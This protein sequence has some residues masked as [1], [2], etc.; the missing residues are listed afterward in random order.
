M[1]KAAGSLVWVCVTTLAVAADNTVETRPEATAGDLSIEQLGNI[2]VPVVEGASKYKQKTTEA[3]SSVTIIVSDEIKKQGY[4]TLADLLRNVPGLYVSYDRLYSFLGIRGFNLG[5]YNNRVLLLINGHRINDSL[6]DGAFIGTE[7]ILDVDLID[8]VE[9]IRGPGSSLYG[10]N[11]F[12]A[13]INVITR[14]GRDM[15][16]NGAEVSG[17]AASHDSY[18]G[19]VSY[20]KRFNNGLELLLSGTI[21]ESLGHGTLYFPDFDQRIHPE[22]LRAR[23][24]GVAR[25]LDADRFKSAFGSLGFR[26]FS[27][28]GGYI[29]REKSNPTA[30]NASDFNDPRSR[31]TD[32]RGYAS[33]KYAH[34]FPGIVDVSA[35]LYYD[36]HESRTFYPFVAQGGMLIRDEQIGEWWGT[37]VQFIKR[38]WERLTLTLGG[39]YRDDFRQEERFRNAQ[40]GAIVGTPIETNRQNYGIYLEGDLAILTNLHV[41]AGFRYDQYGDYD[42]A[43]NPRAALIYNPFDES[44]FKFIYGTAFRAPNFFELRDRRFASS[45]KPE[46]ISTYELVYEQGIAKHLRSSVAGFYNQIDD[47]IRFEGGRYLNIEGADAK[48][49]ELSLDAAWASGIRG[50]ISYTFQH[51]EDRASGDR[52]TDS[53]EHL[54]ALSLTAPVLKDKIFAS[55]QLQYVSRRTT[56]FFDA[57]TQTQA[58]GPDVAGHAIVNLTLF[59]QNLAKGLDLSASVYN[60]LDKRYSDPATPFHQQASIE[61]DRRTFRVKLTYRF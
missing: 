55:V 10:A 38:M 31:T 39:E 20:G 23:D 16:G 7:F 18:K 1:I 42:P 19:R 22:V 11:A 17:E 12:F 58:V 60:V 4:R 26:D 14:K 34:S 51:T 37:E 15:A 50:R 3:P 43:F 27:V 5:D 2:E 8:R 25:N 56:S 54:G 9:I 44:T 40:T 41:N 24:N 13:V 32:D 29:T 49:V 48:G 46:T 6:S 47:L 21:Y 35:Q 52:L 57:S 28:E 61:Q 45:I 59:G 53:P 36:R 33:V 30:P